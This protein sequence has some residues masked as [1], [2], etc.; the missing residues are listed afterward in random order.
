MNFQSTVKQHVILDPNEGNEW[1]LDFQP[2]SVALTVKHL[3]QELTKK[4]REIYLAAWILLF[5]QRQDFLNIHQARVPIT[6]NQEGT[7]EMRDEALSSVGAQGM[8]T[9][10][11]Q[12]SDLDDVQCY[13]GN[14]HLDV[15]VVYRPE[16]YSTFSS[17]TFNDIEMR[18]VAEKP[19][20]I[21]E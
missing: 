2:D 17:S 12:V 7:R 21:D 1:S 16:I 15:D 13:W 4:F 10:G 3:V 9:G 8:D 18:S 11:Y 14:D 20:W 19:I 6:P 5:S